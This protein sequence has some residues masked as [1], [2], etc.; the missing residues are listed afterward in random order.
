M[1]N[2]LFYYI[3]PLLFSFTLSA[4]TYEVGV[5][6]G[7]TN[8]TGDVGSTSFVLPEDYSSRSNGSYG[9]IFK[10]NR[11][12]RHSFRFSVLR[13]RTYGDDSRSDMNRRIARNYRF[14]QA[15][16]EIS[17][18]IEYTFW[19]W[20]PHEPRTQITPYLATGP[21]YFFADHH[22]LG[23]NNNLVKGESFGSFAIPMIF[24]VKINLATHW[25]LAGEFGARYTFTDNLDGSNPSEISGDTNFPSF[26]NP[27]TNDWYMFAGFTLTYSFGRKPCY[28]N[29]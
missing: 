27:N 22:Y 9:L 8:F 23:N 21:T 3:I 19:D 13:A 15:M 12:I 17:A 5:M 4:Q 10:W 7:G 20:D 11:S 2:N 25:V 14:N 29:F 18:A 28:C 24:G 1:R 6:I 26:G 16:T